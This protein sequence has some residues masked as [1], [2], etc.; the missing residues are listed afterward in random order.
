MK[1]IIYLA[2]FVLIAASCSNKDLTVGNC[3]DVLV[4]VRVLV[5]GFNVN[6]VE[7]PETRAAQDVAD[8]SGVKVITLAFYDATGAEVYKS[9]QNRGDA[10]SYTTFGEFSCNLAIG[11]YT[12][13][14]VARG[15]KDGDTFSLTSPTEAAYTGEFAR[16]TFVNTKEVR[17]A[18]NTPLSLS[19]T[20]NRIMAKLA[21]QSTDNR[22]AGIP[23]IR[24]TYGG[25]GK[26]FNPTTGLALSNTG[27][28]VT[29]TISSGVGS[30][31]DIGSYVF[32]SA[33]EQTMNVT[34][35]LL[36]EGDHEL[37][38]KVVE[39]VPFMRNRVTVLRGNMFS[40][41]SPSSAS[42]IVETEWEDQATVNF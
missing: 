14:V 41:S 26:S 34:L 12:M 20:L 32:L 3:D 27:F 30:P 31:I 38:T 1:K 25:G 39:D 9:N 37:F 40:A 42:F 24:I 28:S 2:L 5:D 19:V 35:H 22:S 11:N 18:N 7:F 10:S 16:E 4:P 15:H 29:N 8:Y 13:V 23:K 36:D 6:Q 21:I 33:N 17:V